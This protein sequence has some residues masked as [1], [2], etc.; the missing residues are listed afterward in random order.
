M[1]P[2]GGCLCIE[3]LERRLGRQLNRT[4][5]IDSLINI[6]G[7]LSARLRDRLQRPEGTDENGKSIIANP[8]P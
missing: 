8:G 5:F 2:D 7:L 1:A 3:C 6:A 4:D